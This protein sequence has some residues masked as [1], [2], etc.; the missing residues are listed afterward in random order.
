MREFQGTWARAP[1][2]ERALTGRRATLRAGSQLTV[3]DAASTIIVARTAVTT[4]MSGGAAGVTMLF[5]KY[6]WTRGWDAL[7]VC[8]GVLAGLVGVTAS[9]SVIEPWAAILTGAV[10]AIIFSAAEN[11]AIY[12]LRVDDP[13]SA[14]PLHGVVGAWGVLYTGL[15]AQPDYVVEVYGGYGLGADAEQGKR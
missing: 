10:S 9:C 15:M 13:V 3:A 5:W 8:N 4:T 11:V 1:L 6:Y 2:V 12:R 7:A 14:W